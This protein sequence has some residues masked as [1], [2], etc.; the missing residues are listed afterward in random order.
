MIHYKIGDATTPEGDGQKLICHVCND[1]GCWSK[2]FVL[3]ISAR[4][5]EPERAY[6]DAWTV[7]RRGDVF[8]LGMT[9]I[10][11]VEN[12][13]SVANMIAQRGYSLPGK[14]AADLESLE[15]CLKT[16]NFYA[17]THPGTTIHMPRICCGL[18]GLSWDEVEPVIAKTLGKHDV[19]VYDLD[20]QA[21]L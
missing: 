11:R 16:A 20:A 17:K 4:W 6:R 8:Y 5:S 3:A 15:K 14:P 19:T 18:G 10:I 12:N 13:I 1:S 7:R 2:G 9:Q 21:A